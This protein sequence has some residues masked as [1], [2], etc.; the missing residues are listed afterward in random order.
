MKRLNRLSLGMLFLIGLIAFGAGTANAQSQT[1]RWNLQKGQAF[2]LSMQQDMT[3]K[4]QIPGLGPQEMPMKQDVE[5]TWNVV[6][7]DQDSFTIEQVV[8]RVQ[9]SVKS[10][11]MNIE[12]DSDD[13]EPKDATAKQ[14]YESMKDV[15]GKKTI[16]KM[17]RQGEVIESEGDA[18]TAGPAK[19]MLKNMTGQ[20]ALALP[21]GALEVG[22]TWDTNTEMNMNGMGMKSKNTFKYVGTEKVDGKELH[23]F[24]VTIVT[25]IE[26]GPQG[27]EVSVKDQEHKGVI[28][29]DA[30]EGRLISS[31][32]TQKLTMELSIQG[33][34][35][36][37]EI[38]GTT[39]VTMTPIKK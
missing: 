19:E 3:Q 1:L 26:G 23:K 32:A 21:E 13:G 37:Q 16:Q 6:E 15:I 7:A 27:A 33:Q 18:A 10:A 11:F 35:L 4:M 17:S 22:K 39:N 25:E 8:S 30:E 34:N 5:M 31:K 28:Y 36:E 24:E 20:T 14:M 2:K 12:F 29:F 38:D 9:L